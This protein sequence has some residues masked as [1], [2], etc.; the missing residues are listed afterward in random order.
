MVGAVLR[1]VFGH[2]LFSLFV[3]ISVLCMRSFV[4]V[5]VC[6]VRRVVRVVDGSSALFTA[7]THC[8]ISLCHLN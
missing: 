7:I 1:I 5:H 3:R 6:G 4:C 2:I 8:S